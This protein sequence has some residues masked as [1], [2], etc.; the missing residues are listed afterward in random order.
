MKVYLIYYNFLD[1]FGEIKCI[2]GVQTYL[3]YLANLIS[4][5]YGQPIIIQSSKIPFERNVDNI[6][7]IG[8]ISKGLFHKKIRSDLYKKALNLIDTDKDILIFGADQASVYTKYKKSVLIQHGVSWDLPSKYFKYCLKGIPIPNSLKKKY[9]IYRALK[10][11]NNCPNRVCVDYNFLNWYRTQINTEQNGNIWII[12]NFIDIPNNFIPELPR[13]WNK[14]I[15]I[16]FA[17][18]FV[19]MR[20]FNLFNLIIKKL[21]SN[22]NDIHITLAGEEL[23]INLIKENFSYNN[24]IQIIKYLPNE[25]LKIHS[26]QDISVIP[27]LGSEGTS[28]SLLEAMAAGCAVIATNVGGLTNIIINNYNGLLVMPNFNALYDALVNL[29]INK[30]LR[31]KLALKAIETSHNSFNLKNWQISWTNV[32]N[33]IMQIK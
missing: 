24:K 4:N 17:R 5:N 12:P 28:F 16:I 26:E 2:G 31:N 6:K 22:F 15:K 33:Q 25:S 29:I 10:Y 1:S 30:E 32:I 21:L 11:F 14:P 27:S 3:S 19:E 8:V 7:I 13:K 9:N 18:R 23:E 20:G